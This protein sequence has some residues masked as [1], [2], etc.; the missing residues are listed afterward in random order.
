MEAVEQLGAFKVK[1]LL[2]IVHASRPQYSVRCLSERG[3]L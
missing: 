1:R 2:L 3:A